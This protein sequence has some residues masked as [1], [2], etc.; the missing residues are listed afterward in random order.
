MGGPHDV[1]EDREPEAPKIDYSRS[2]MGGNSM[3]GYDKLAQGM[4][5]EPGPA[6]TDL[7]SEIFGNHVD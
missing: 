3:E 6:C 5:M 4:D 7:L 2:M 1:A